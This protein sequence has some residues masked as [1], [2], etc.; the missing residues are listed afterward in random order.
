MEIKIENNGDETLLKIIGRLD[1]ATAGDFEK[2]IAPVIADN[3][4]KVILDCIDF[5]YISSSGLRLFLIMQKAARAKDGKLIIRN[6]NADIK[7]VFDMTGF[8]NL[9]LF[10]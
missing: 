2:A 10:E 4:Q 1:T 7:S 6:M 3:M 5:E 9:F 8:T